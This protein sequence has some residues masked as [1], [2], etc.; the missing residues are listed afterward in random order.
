M[1]KFKKLG[2]NLNE[3]NALRGYTDRSKV[4]FCDIS[5]GVKYM[6]RDD[7]VIDYAIYNDTLIM[8]ESC[9]DYKNAF[10]YP[11]GKDEQG[12]LNEIENYCRTK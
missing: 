1:L 11:I 2:D 7:F 4:S 8:R 9:P 5:V 12:A 10:Y 6:W 3:I